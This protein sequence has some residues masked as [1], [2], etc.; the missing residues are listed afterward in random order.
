MNQDFN[1]IP[2]SLARIATAL[3]K[4]SAGNVSPTQVS[5]ASI[6]P[7]APAITPTAPS[8]APSAPKAPAKPRTKKGLPTA[9]ETPMTTPSAVEPTMPTASAVDPLLGVTPPPAAPLPNT[10]AQN[11]LEDM[12]GATKPAEPTT[13]VYTVEQLQPLIMQF[14]QAAATPAENDAR[15]NQLNGLLMLAGVKAL[16]ELTSDK[17]PAFV[18]GLRGIGVAV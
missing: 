10:P 15:I 11:A 18:E 9:P 16:T 7:A 6:A 17:M 14:V 8:E 13:T 3:E 12:L 5:V 2:D 4:I 1:T